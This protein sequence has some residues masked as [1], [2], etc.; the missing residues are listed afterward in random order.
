PETSHE[1]SEGRGPRETGTEK[2]TERPSYRSNPLQ[3]EG[4]ALRT[5]PFHLKTYFCC[6]FLS[7]FLEYSIR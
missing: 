5:P 4:V 2:Q 7:G 6:S 3:D 1:R